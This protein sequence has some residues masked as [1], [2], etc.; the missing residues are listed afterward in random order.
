MVLGKFLTTRKILEW[1]CNIPSFGFQKT[2]LG[3]AQTG[4]LF[5]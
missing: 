3:H 1:K 5:N 2:R 4:F